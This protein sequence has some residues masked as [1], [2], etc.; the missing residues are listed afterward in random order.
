MNEE[1]I[2]VNKNNLIDSAK[3]IF[4]LFIEPQDKKNAA[5]ALGL[6][7]SEIK[8]VEDEVDKEK[9]PDRDYFFFGTQLKKWK[10]QNNSLD[11][12]N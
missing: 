1:K 7:K 11:N 9:I 8:I 6:N 10:R 4:R 3:A 2:P 12:G 5:K